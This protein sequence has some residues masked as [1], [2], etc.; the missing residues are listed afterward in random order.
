MSDRQRLLP[1]LP[2]SKLTLQYLGQ[3]VGLPSLFLKF[4]Q[5]KESIMLKMPI[6]VVSVWFT[7]MLAMMPPT[8]FA[9]EESS[10]APFECYQKALEQLKYARELVEAQQAENQRLLENVRKL[11]ESNQY[12]ILQNQSLIYSLQQ[13]TKLINAKGVE[14]SQTELNVNGIVSANVFKSKIKEFSPYN[15]VEQDAADKDFY[16]DKDCV[17]GT[18]TSAL[19]S[20]KNGSNLQAAICTCLHSKRGRGWF[21]WN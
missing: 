4:A 10:C 1:T 13:K 18:I 11:A 2:P 19:V 16:E 8:L 9:S 5:F 14:A 6:V 21:C 17:F 15:T 20:H 7:V 3:S 12:L